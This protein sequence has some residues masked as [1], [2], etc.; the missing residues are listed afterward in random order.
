MEKISR[1]KEGDRRRRAELLSGAVNAL[2]LYATADDF[3]KPHFYDSAKQFSADAQK[4]KEKIS[5][6]D[7][8]PIDKMDEIFL[9]KIPV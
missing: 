6:F 2:K 4:L 8:S 5:S 3:Y 1:A 7:Y 9:N